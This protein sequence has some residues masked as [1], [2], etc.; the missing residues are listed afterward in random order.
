MLKHW[1]KFKLYYGF[2]NFKILLQ[3]QPGLTEQFL[4]LFSIRIY[5]FSYFFF[6]VRVIQFIA[7]TW[8]KVF[9]SIAKRSMMV[10]TANFLVSILPCVAYDSN[11]SSIL[12]DIHY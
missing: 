10:F 1:V 11:K 3:I 2:I 7:L 5:N 8:L 4:K 9:L 6:L 12:N